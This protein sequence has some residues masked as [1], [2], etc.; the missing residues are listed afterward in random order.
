MNRHYPIFA[1]RA[2]RTGAPR[3]RR[4]R[5]RLALNDDKIA[6]PGAIGFEATP[7]LSYSGS[8]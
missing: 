3:T 8:P 1:A 2:A 5:Q 4:A 7:D 6:A